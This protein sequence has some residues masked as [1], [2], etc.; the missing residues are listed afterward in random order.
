MGGTSG[1][2]RCAPDRVHL[3]NVL[4]GMSYV[5][6]Y[7]SCR[8]PLVSATSAPRCLPSPRTGRTAR[9]APGAARGGCGPGCAVTGRGRGTPPVSGRAVRGLPPRLPE[10]AAHPRPGASSGPGGCPVQ[11]P[12]GRPGAVPPLSRARELAGRRHRRRRIPPDRPYALP[13]HRVRRPGRHPPRAAGPRRRTGRGGVRR[14]ADGSAHRGPAAGTLRRREPLPVSGAG[15]G[16]PGG[17]AG[18]AASAEARRASARRR[19][20][21]ASPAA[22]PPLGLGAELVAQ[23]CTVLTGSRGHR[24]VARKDGSAP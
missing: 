19:G 2:R 9:T 3:R 1:R 4:P 17:T 8:E 24:V 14:A 12:A 18:R 10:P 11:T 23:G 13:V 20:R 6:A 7:V 22:R 21:P 15:C 16:P 5:P